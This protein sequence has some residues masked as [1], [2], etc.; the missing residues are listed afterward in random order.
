MA[1]RF[2]QYK[3]VAP[4]LVEH[5]AASRHRVQV[6]RATLSKRGN[7]PVDAEL[8]DLSIYG[9][10]FACQTGYGEGDR[11]WLRFGDNLPVAA[12][13]VWNDGEYLGCRFD[14]PIDRRLVRALTLVIY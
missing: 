5:R 4:A 11:L 12:T 3:S 7:H 6:T 10:R 8:H 13:A 9:C 1:T 2:S 14:A